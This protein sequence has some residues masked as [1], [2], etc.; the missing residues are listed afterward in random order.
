MTF[1]HNS[2]NYLLGETKKEQDR[3]LYLINKFFNG[4]TLWERTQLEN[5]NGLVG[6]CMGECS[7]FIYGDHFCLASHNSD[8]QCQYAGERVNGGNPFQLCNYF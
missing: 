3:Y 2:Q 1:G 5:E 4:Q 8:M 6:L 7:T